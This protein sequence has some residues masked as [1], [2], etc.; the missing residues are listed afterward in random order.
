MLEA[1][2]LSVAGRDCPLVVVDKTY[3]QSLNDKLETLTGLL[4]AWAWG[5]STNGHP[6]TVSFLHIHKLDYRSV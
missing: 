6:H 4:F 3:R 2:G 5:K 1:L